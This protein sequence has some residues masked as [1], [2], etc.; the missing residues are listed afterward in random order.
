[1][2]LSYDIST[3]FQHKNDLVRKGNE[4]EA[5]QSYAA[6]LFASRPGGSS[7]GTG[8]PT[9]GPN[10]GQG[11]GS[12]S[13]AG[14]QMSAGNAQLSAQFSSGGRSASATGTKS[15]AAPRAAPT[16][17]GTST[18]RSAAFVQ[19][20][21]DVSAQARKGSADLTRQ[22]NSGGRSA[23]FT[24]TKSYVAPRAAATLQGT[25]TAR[26]AAFVA[27]SQKVSAQA[28][29]GSADLTRQFNS[30]GRSAAFTGTKSY[31][32][33]RAAA[34]LQGTSTQRSAAF[35]QSSREVSAQARQGSA[36]LT[37]QLESGGRSKAFT[38]TESY[39]APAPAKRMQDSFATLAKPV[40]PMAA[41]TA[42]TPLK[43]KPDGESEEASPLDELPEWKALKQSNAEVET[44]QRWFDARQREAAQEETPEQWIN[45]RNA[46]ASTTLS[47][48]SL[49]A[50]V[51][52]SAMK[53]HAALVSLRM[54]TLS[55]A[56]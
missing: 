11:G 44:V 24:G 47:D 12:S 27:S 17:Q 51:S 53:T 37:R 8:T 3:N 21:R 32:A 2:A 38:G 19:S 5:S 20:S 50:T 35:V 45:R 6:Y 25:S 1:M 40:Q 4:I 30:G 52:V 48:A 33:P 13:G 34:T 56:A 15:Y 49:N 9:S 55:L 18:A 39:V 41:T 26:S 31:V 10:K 42:K 46:E 54:A 22:F 23:A 14:R 29:K 43:T 16:L 7:K 36:D 28:R